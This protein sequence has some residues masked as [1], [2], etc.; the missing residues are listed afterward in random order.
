MEWACVAQVGHSFEGLG[1]K[2][3]FKV[4]VLFGPKTVWS[5]RVGLG[6]KLSGP[7]VVSFGVGQGGVDQSGC[8]VLLAHPPLS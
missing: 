3:K 1:F 4:H 6:K 7:K 8:C 2:V 5:K